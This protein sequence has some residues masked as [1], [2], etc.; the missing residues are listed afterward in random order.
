MRENNVCNDVCYSF[1]LSVL[2]SEEGSEN[3]ALEECTRDFNDITS[4]YYVHA[5]MMCDKA[6]CTAPIA[7]EIL[8]PEDYRTT[9]I[10]SEFGFILMI[11]T[12]MLL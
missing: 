7:R 8:P 1:H 9:E 12:R 2:S 4:P 5:T 11:E 6:K 3:K 10:D